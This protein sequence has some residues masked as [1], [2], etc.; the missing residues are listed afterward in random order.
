MAKYREYNFIWLQEIYPFIS[1]TPVFLSSNKSFG[2]EGEGN[3]AGSSSDSSRFS[4]LLKTKWI[5]LKAN[6]QYEKNKLYIETNWKEP[7]ANESFPTF[8]LSCD[9]E[10]ISRKSSSLLVVAAFSAIAP[11]DEYSTWRIPASST[12][13]EESDHII[14]IRIPTYYSQYCKSCYKIIKI[15]FIP[16]KQKHKNAFQYHHH[17]TKIHFIKA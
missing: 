3:A 16:N 5:F 10:K 9:G 2:L 12:L 4:P 15:Q 17:L 13:W 1:E 6:T 8:D 11:T 7:Y 14:T